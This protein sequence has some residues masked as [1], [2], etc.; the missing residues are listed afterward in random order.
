VILAANK[1]ERK[2]LSMK[3][4][5][6]IIRG[7]KGGFVYWRGPSMDA[8]KALTELLDMKHSLWRPDGEHPIAAT[9]WC[10]ETGEVQ[11]FTFPPMPGQS[12][13]PVA[14]APSMVELPLSRGGIGSFMPRSVAA[15]YPRDEKQTYLDL[16]R[17]NDEDSFSIALPN[18]QVKV[19]LGIEPA[20]VPVDP[21]KW[22]DENL[23]PALENVAATRQEWHVW[24]LEVPIDDWTAFAHFGQVAQDPGSSPLVLEAL[25]ALKALALSDLRWEGDIRSGPYLMPCFGTGGRVAGFVLKQDN[26]GTTFAILP[27]GVNCPWAEDFQLVPGGSKD[28]SV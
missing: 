12:P 2:D 6:T 28:A 18:D 23:L 25:E 13:A 11:E 10:E 24:R 3:T 17:H 27:P 19:M 4:Y 9:V 26:D 7:H 15:I 14:A 16:D 20:P 22:V 1:A 5:L 21:Q 8:T